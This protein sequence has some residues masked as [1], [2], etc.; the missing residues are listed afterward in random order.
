MARFCHVA[1]FGEWL[2]SARFCLFQLVSA[3]IYLLSTPLFSSYPCVQAKTG[4]HNNN[5]EQSDRTCRKLQHQKC[6]LLVA[7]DGPM[8][9]WYH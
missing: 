1:R 8:F 9:L 6:K 5:Y 4:D 7:I 2:D 3:T